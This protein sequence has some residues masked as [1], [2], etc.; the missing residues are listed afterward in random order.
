LIGGMVNK[1]GMTIKSLVTVK[2]LE[3]SSG[4]V[5]FS[6]TIKGEEFIGQIERPTYDQVIG[7]IKAAVK[8]S[9]DESTKEI[10]SYFSIRGYITKIRS[11]GDDI[12]AQISVGKDKKLATGQKFIV[13]TLEENE[14]PISGKKSCDLIDTGN[15]LEVTNQISSKNAWTLASDVKI[16]AIKINQLVQRE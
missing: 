4:R 5:V 10:G 6:K 16:G 3:V 7:G 1:P 13:Y 14:A 11:N 12:I 2:I 15:R 9:L 8:K